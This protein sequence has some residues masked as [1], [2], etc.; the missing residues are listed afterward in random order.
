V[1]SIVIHYAHPESAFC[2]LYGGGVFVGGPIGVNDS[3]MQWTAMNEGLIDLTV[4]RFVRVRGGS[5]ML[6]ATDG[7]IYYR[8]ASHVWTET[9]PGLVANGLVIDSGDSTRAYAACE[10]GL[11]RSLNS[12]QSWFASNTG[13][14]A[15]VPVN[16]VARRDASS[17]VLYVGTRGAGV[18]ESVD[19]GA[20][21]RP[22]GPGLPGDNDVRAV[23]C[24]VGAGAPDSAGVFAGTRA[25]GLYQSTYSTPATPMTW[26]KL[27]DLYRK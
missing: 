7:G 17:N 4:R 10:S 18:F 27:K 2:A 8:G 11:Y 14:P 23:L 15:G 20:S 6:A 24:T 25:N 21:W 22:F 16:C 1:R 12:G 5:F 9:G 3:L 13:L 26:G 19:S